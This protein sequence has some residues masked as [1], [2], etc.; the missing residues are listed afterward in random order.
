MKTKSESTALH[1]PARRGRGKPQSSAMRVEV[2]KPHDGINKGEIL[3]KSRE[4]AAMMIA[5]GFYKE[6]SEE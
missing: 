4:T 1:A 3:V 2:V 5:K 6:V